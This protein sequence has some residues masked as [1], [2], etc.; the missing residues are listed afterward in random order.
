MLEPLA[1]AIM[2]IRIWQDD[3]AGER[4]DDSRNPE[5]ISP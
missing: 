3:V 4:H 2:A 5:K 1:F